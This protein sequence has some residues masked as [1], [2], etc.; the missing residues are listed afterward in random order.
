MAGGLTAV[1]ASNT[2]YCVC[3]AEITPGLRYTLALAENS[4]AIEIG[5]GIASL[6]LAL[7]IAS[8]R[9]WRD[10]AS[11]L[12]FVSLLVIAEFFAFEGVFSP[13]FSIISAASIVL[14]VFLVGS[15]IRVAKRGGSI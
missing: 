5:L 14:V 6:G 8:G 12:G 11:L 4:D 10:R 3:P 15:V 2:F 1:I 13:F 7:A 9:G